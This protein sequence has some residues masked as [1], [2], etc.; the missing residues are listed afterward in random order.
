MKVSSYVACERLI[1]DLKEHERVIRN[2]KIDWLEDDISESCASRVTRIRRPWW[3]HLV[4]LAVVEPFND[5][6]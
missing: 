5:G 4:C 1:A 6:I 2:M 3:P